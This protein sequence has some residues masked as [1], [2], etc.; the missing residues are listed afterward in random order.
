[1]VSCPV[2]SPVLWATCSVGLEYVVNRSTADCSDLGVLTGTVGIPPSSSW[3][4]FQK[5]SR[6]I[7]VR[8]TN[9]NACGK[10]FCPIREKRPIDTKESTARGRR[11]CGFSAVLKFSLLGR[12]LWTS[13]SEPNRRPARIV[14]RVELL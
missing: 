3:E 8:R 4:K 13:D 7:L 12:K 14:G 6:K 10:Q 5:D 9:W 2:G 1:M 11:C